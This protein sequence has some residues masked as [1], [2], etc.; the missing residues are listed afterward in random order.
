MIQVNMWKP[1]MIYSRLVRALNSKAGKRYISAR[2]EAVV[3]M[4]LIPRGLP[5]MYRSGEGNI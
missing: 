4:T 5:S 3:Q 2:T 1:K